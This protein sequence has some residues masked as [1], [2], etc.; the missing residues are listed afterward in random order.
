VDQRE[1]VQFNAFERSTFKHRNI[2]E[3]K[4]AWKTS[5]RQPEQRRPSRCF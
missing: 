5:R 2:S 4:P 3:I 1:L